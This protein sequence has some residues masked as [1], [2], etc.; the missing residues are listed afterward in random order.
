MDDLIKLFGKRLGSSVIPLL[1][2]DSD[3][4]ASDST[5]RPYFLRRGD[6]ANEVGFIDWYLIYW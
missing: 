1:L 3:V 5:Q 4:R 2:A 6:E